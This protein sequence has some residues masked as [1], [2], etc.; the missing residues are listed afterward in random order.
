MGAK[1]IAVRG[2]SVCWQDRHPAHA[3][4]LVELLGPFGGFD[5]GLRVE[6]TDKKATPF[7]RGVPR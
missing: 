5:A 4:P 7:Q 2:E 1:R 6:F 3:P